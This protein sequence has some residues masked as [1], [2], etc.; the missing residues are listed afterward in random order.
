MQPEFRPGFRPQY[1]G[2]A[3][4][5]MGPRGPRPQA[6]IPHIPFDF[7]MSP[8]CFPMAV[9]PECE[10]QR[11]QHLEGFSNKKKIKKISNFSVFIIL[12]LRLSNEE[13]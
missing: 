6:F 12:I 1:R 3:P 4:N 5:R 11:D 7:T 2:P 10:V 13:K 9:D 8:N